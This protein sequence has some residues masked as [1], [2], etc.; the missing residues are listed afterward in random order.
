MR[1]SILMGTREDI[2]K[3]R[4]KQTVNEPVP[5]TGH[6]YTYRAEPK[7]YIVT[8]NHPSIK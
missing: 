3:R 1:K 6:S 8:F 7:R 4:A 5:F 2:I